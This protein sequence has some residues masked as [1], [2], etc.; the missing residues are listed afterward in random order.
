V[1]GVL[2]VA[3][4]VC[5]SVPVGTVV[6]DTLTVT[7]PR[8]ERQLGGVA[9][10]TVVE[11]DGSRSDLAELL[12]EI[13]GVQIRRYGGL[14]APTLPSIRGSTA[15]QVSILIDGLPMS[16]AQNGYLDLSTLPLDRFVRAEV[17]R[18]G[19]PARFGAAGGVGAINLVTRDAGQGRSELQF[20]AGSFGEAGGRLAAQARGA[21]MNALVLAHA[22]RSDGQFRY[23]DDNWTPFNPDDD[24]LSTRSNAWF[25]ER[26][27]LVALRN[28][29][30]MGPRLRV[31]V[32]MYAREAG[33][34]GPYGGAASPE[35]TA[36]VDRYDLH[37]GLADAMN[38]YGVEVSARHDQESLDDPTG[39][40]GWDP[41]GTTRSRSDHLLVRLH[42]RLDR[43][44]PGNWGEATALAVCDLQR[45]RFH[46]DQVDRSDP[47]RERTGVLGGMDL[48]WMLAD[49][50]LTVWPSLRQQRYEDDFPGLPILPHLPPPPLEGPHVHEDWAPSLAVVWEA[51]PG[52]LFLE[53]R[54]FRSRRIPTWIELFGQLGGADGN[55]ELTPELVD[56]REL[57]LRLRDDGVRI[58]WALFRMDVEDAI[59][60]RV[61]S[62]LTSKAENIGRTRVTGHELELSLD[63][64]ASTSTW[65]SLTQQ[66]TVDRGLDPVYA[67]KELLHQPAWTVVLG[68]QR[69]WGDWS[70]RGR[71]LTE[72]G[73]W[74]DRYNGPGARVPPRTLVSAAVSRDLSGIAWNH[75]ITLNLE[76]L[77]L[78]DN[79]ARDVDGYPLPGRS[80]R[81]TLTIR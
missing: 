33:R 13:A 78:T 50:R 27:A 24:I 67:G 20:S 26:G 66:K 46:F 77:N 44:L 68:G 35:A 10:V 65:I 30:S 73:N 56:G 22:R 2:L 25:R 47:V 5:A 17:F 52:R 54:R 55:R 71:V 60:W 70:L 32:G 1:I 6:Q 61:N 63:L 19:L 57:A 23:L 8:A 40:V 18:G 28:S 58:R 21:G 69:R 75:G 37:L 72:A 15:T 11:L 31:A 59:V 14:G 62:Q 43:R 76:G 42:G 64:S 81:A 3:A 16:D 39:D 74:N 34:P 53:A 41:P 49:R 38:R 29:S 51:H 80:Y 4:A 79:L 48:Q 12:E 36:H 7:A 9:T 45:Q